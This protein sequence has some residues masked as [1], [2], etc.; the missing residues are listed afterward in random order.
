MPAPLKVIDD[1]PA[2]G[3]TNVTVPLIMFCFLQPVEDGW[4]GTGREVSKSR[5]G[6]AWPAKTALR[7]MWKWGEMSAI[8]LR[9]MEEKS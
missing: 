1:T 9:A 4:R 7:K 6:D 2:T 3:I 5:A 8:V